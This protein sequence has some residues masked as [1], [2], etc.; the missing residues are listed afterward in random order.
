MVLQG[1]MLGWTGDIIQDMMVCASGGLPALGC[2]SINLEVKSAM[3][4]WLHRYQNTA[5]CQQVAPS[6]PSAFF[7]YGLN[8]AMLQV[9]AC[10]RTSARQRIYR[11]SCIEESV[12][13]E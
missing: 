6:P 7:N 10:K 11:C 5:S 4:A 2:P 13:L 12:A 9:R 8:S 1:W 3:L